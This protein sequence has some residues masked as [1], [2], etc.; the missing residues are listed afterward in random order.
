MSSIEVEWTYAWEE[1]C[2]K[3]NSE[4]NIIERSRLFLLNMTDRNAFFTSDPLDIFS[5]NIVLERTDTM[6]LQYLQTSPYW[7]TL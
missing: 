3:N 7:I 2:I 5:E 1:K 4:Y 6:L